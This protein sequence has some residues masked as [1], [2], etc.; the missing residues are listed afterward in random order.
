MSLRLRITLVV[1]LVVTAAVAVVGQRVYAAAELELVEEVDTEV[2]GRAAG[3]GTFVS[4]PQFREAFTRSALQDLA[5]DGFFERR[6][7]QSFLDQTA[8]DNFSRVVAPDGEAI[9]NVGTS[10]SVDLAPTDYPR[11]GD[12]P[13]LSDGSV[14]GGRA[15]IATIAANDVLCRSPARWARSIS[16]SMVSPI[17]SCSSRF[18]PSRWLRQPGGSSRAAR[19]P[20]FDD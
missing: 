4:G 17:A 14:D 13:V 8:R 12:A 1:V 9:F 20:R 2:Q 16:R 3:F 7:S 6:D 19:S 10:F 18:S 11:V 15:R 5:A